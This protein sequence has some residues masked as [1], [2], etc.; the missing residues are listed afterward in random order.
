VPMKKRRS[1]KPIQGV[2]AQG[3]VTAFGLSRAATSHLRKGYQEKYHGK[4]RYARFVFAFDISL[5]AI[6]LFLVGTN[7]YLATL[8]PSIATDLQ[9]VL[10]AP[11]L[12]TAQPLALQAK[13]TNSGETARSGLHF[14]WNLPPG[15]EVLSAEPAMDANNEAFIGALAPGE[16]FYA[17][18]VVEIYTD[19]PSLRLGFHVSD[20]T[21]TAAGELIRPIVG[22]GLSVKPLIDVKRILPGALIPYEV[23]N[24]TSQAMQSINLR[25]IGRAQI[26]G[27]QEETIDTLNSL[28]R[29]I[30]FLDPQ[31]SRDT[32]IA[33]SI[34][35]HV[36]FERGDVL[37]VLPDSPLRVQASPSTG[38]FAH[39]S[40]SQA[41]APLRLFI[42]HPQLSSGGEPYAFVSVKAGDSSLDI[43]L[44][45]AEHSVSGNWFVIPVIQT[46]V[47]EV[48]GKAATNVITTSFQLKAEARYYADTG[49][50]I[51]IGALPPQVGKETTYWVSLALEPTTAD[52]Q[53]L[54]IR[55]TLGPSVH[56]TGRSALPYGGGIVESGDGLA[57]VLPN[58]PAD[59]SGLRALIEVALTPTQNMVGQV[60][61]LLQQ[62]TAKATEI[63]SHV[64]LTDSKALIDTNLL[65]DPR[66]AGRG[67]VTK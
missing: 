34:N 60:P 65:G 3:I 27:K 8:R 63:R 29:R 58:A 33:V 38:K 46:D 13:L 66:A 11:P 61:T 20:N 7:I 56:L 1:E 32:K 31:S 6:A 47:G 41:D 14:R 16:D 35:G 18:V 2:A 28:E 17:N 22:S 15:T 23:K 62:I 37:E 9:L 54:E 48:L 21:E 55:A 51:G 19:Q 10:E 50:Q 36:L 64:L 40:I 43:P 24:E 25:V 49:D 52:L 57:W 39:V 5:F 30:V 44:Q 26:D 53:D 67:V 42:Y 12:Q 45:D 59:K 4:Y